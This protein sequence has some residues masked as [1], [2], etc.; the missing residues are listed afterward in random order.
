V[1]GG[2]RRV[3]PPC[4][5]KEQRGKRPKKHHGDDKPLDKRSEKT[6]GGSEETLP[7]RGLGG[8]VWACGHTSE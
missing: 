7:E 8:C 5:H 4:G 2:C 6:L 1:H 3:D